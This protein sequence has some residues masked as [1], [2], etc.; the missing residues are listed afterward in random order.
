MRKRN[1]IPLLSRG[2]PDFLSAI[3]RPLLQLLFLTLY[4][5]LLTIAIVLRVAIQSIEL[6]SRISGL[7]RSGLRTAR[8]WII[9]QLQ[10]VARS[11]KGRRADHHLVF[12][13]FPTISWAFRKRRLIVIGVGATIFTSIFVTVITL[14]KDL[15]SPEGLRN[16]ESALSTKIY[17]RN[18]VLL[19]KIFKNENRTLVRLEDIPEH[20]I[21]ATVAIEDSDF[22]RHR[23]YSFRGMLRALRTT[24]LEG[25]VAG[26]STITQQLVKN[27]LL[28]SEQTL[29]R[30]LREVILA[31]L[32]ET[33]MTKDEILTMYFNEVGYGGATYGIEEASQMYFGKSVSNLTLAESAILAGLPAAPTRYSPFGTHPE[34]AKFRQHEVLRR[35]VED[36][37]ITTEQAEKAKSEKLTFASQKTDILAPH[38]VMYVKDLL[39]EKFGE[40]LVERGGLEVVTTLD[41][42]IQRLAQEAVSQ[43]VT[44]LGDLNITNGAALVTHPATGEVLAMVGS[45]DFFDVEH[46]GQVNVTLRPRQP[47]SA[48][49]PVNYVVALENGMTAASLI[50]DTPITFAVPNQ[51][52]YTPRNYDGKFHGTITL[53]EA[54]ANSYNVPAVKTLSVFGVD[55]MLEK[56]QAMGIS[57]WTDRSRYGLSLTLGGGEVTMLDLSVVYGTLATAGKRQNPVALREVHDPR[58]RVLYRNACPQEEAESSGFLVSDEDTCQP[59]EVVKPEVAFIIT[60]ILA[61]NQAR[62]PAFG[63]YSALNIPGHQVAVKTGTTQNLRDNWTIGYTQDILVATWVGNNDNTPMRYVASGLTG[64]SSIWSAIMRSLLA[65]LPPHRFVPPRTIVKRQI[66]PTTASLS[67]ASCPGREEYFIPGTEPAHAC[68]PEVSQEPKPVETLDAM[69]NKA[70]QRLRRMSFERLLGEKNPQR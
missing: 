69:R 28:T 17:D 29:K 5:L 11:L 52:P 43:E 13:T 15:P 38:F 10:E 51:P 61:D 49:K 6:V 16:R 47:G 70:K 63:L 36:G 48:I 7:I 19:Y 32:V 3:G 21:Q 62:A 35:L 40:P 25:R 31:I 2:M 68:A 54:L 12:A 64:A 60:N 14:I 55:K 53:R 23:G 34:L 58:G 24:L 4:A 18:G 65:D 46:D 42:R 26:G 1:P 57:T 44:R 56:G 37:Y 22:Y 59:Q 27:T 8:G 9:P 20:L 41:A 66:C 67:C 33:R 30:K 45:R 39:V 50:A